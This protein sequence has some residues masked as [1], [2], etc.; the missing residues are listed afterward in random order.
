M[1][2][3][4]SIRNPGST[5]ISRPRLRPR[6][7]APIE[8]AMVAATC[9][10][11]SASRSRRLAAPVG[12]RCP[13]ASAESPV[14]RVAR[15]AVARP[16]TRAVRTDTTVA[17]ARASRL[18]PTSPPRGSRPGSRRARPRTPQKARTVPT[19]PPSPTARVPP[20]RADARRARDALRAP[21]ARRA[22]AGA[23]WPGRA[24]GWRR[25]RRPRAA[26]RPPPP[27]GRAGPDARSP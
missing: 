4:L 14:P 9:E 10:T 3:T 16:S 13:S 1:A 19:V 20:S 22:R 24:A 8:R 23:P 2:I 26:G 17:H 18:G 11:T 25:W 15:S 27:G 12:A 5:S 21:G 6:R 7:P